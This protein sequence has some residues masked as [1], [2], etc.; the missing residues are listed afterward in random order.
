MPISTRLVRTLEPSQVGQPSFS[1]GHD[2][3]FPLVPTD[4]VQIAI[5]SLPPSLPPSPLPQPPPHNVQTS[6][7]RAS[8]PDRQ[9]TP[10]AFQGQARKPWAPRKRRAHGSDTLARWP[11]DTHTARQSE[12]G[13]KKVVRPLLPRGET[14]SSKTFSIGD[15]SPKDLSTVTDP[16]PSAPGVNRVTRNALEGGGGIYSS[17]GL[18]LCASELLVQTGTGTVGNPQPCDTGTQCCH[19]LVCMHAHTPSHQE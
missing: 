5:P 12:R 19:V 17:D 16:K 1:A 14:V 6:S 9:K 15:S 10:A 4:H 3:C 18:L 7:P 11:A 13:E 8:L 2:R